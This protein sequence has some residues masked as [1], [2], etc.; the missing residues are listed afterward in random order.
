MK[1]FLSKGS[2]GLLL[3]A[4]LASASSISGA[5]NAAPAGAQGKTEALW[6]GQAGFRIKTPQGKMILIDPWITGGLRRR[7]CT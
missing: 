5:Q 1:N 6:L 3:A 7:Q 4:V 2:L